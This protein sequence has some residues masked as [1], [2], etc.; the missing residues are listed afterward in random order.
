MGKI[1]KHHNDY[2]QKEVIRSIGL[3]PLSGNFTPQ[4]YVEEESSKETVDPETIE[5]L[6][7]R[8][9]PEDV[10]HFKEL[11]ADVGDILDSLTPREKKVLKLRFGIGLSKDYTLEE[12]GKLMGV[13]KERVRQMEAKALR[14][15]RHP[16]RADIL[17]QYLE[18]VEYLGSPIDIKERFW[19]AQAEPPH[20]DDIEWWTYKDWLAYWERKKHVDET[21]AKVRVEKKVELE[22]L[23]TLLRSGVTN[24][25]GED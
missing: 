13:T 9:T 22:R 19:K 3:L 20:P 21:L 2:L 5:A 6:I 24:Y 1:N 4:Y 15:M 17:K 23:R 25:R 11:E 12:V 10:V 7:D 18:G 14:K 8:G 16:T